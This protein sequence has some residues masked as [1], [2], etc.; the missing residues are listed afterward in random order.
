MIHAA[1]PSTDAVVDLTS[2][3]DQEAPNRPMDLVVNSDELL[4]DLELQARTLGV[5]PSEWYEVKQ[6]SLLDILRFMEAL[7]APEST[8]ARS[9]A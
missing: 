8:G 6:R 4:A 7:R 5:G 1:G 2:S 9:S 3:V